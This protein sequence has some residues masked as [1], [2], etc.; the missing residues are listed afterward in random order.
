MNTE[1]PP[2]CSQDLLDITSIRPFRVPCLWRLAGESANSLN[3]HPT[4]Y[5]ATCG[6]KSR[7]VPRPARKSRCRPLDRS[8]H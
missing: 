5:A 2:A 8:N 4:R 6:L 7:N 3:L 1:K